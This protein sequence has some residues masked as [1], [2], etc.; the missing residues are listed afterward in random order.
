MLTFLAAKRMLGVEAPVGKGMI[1]KAPVSPAVRQ[2]VE[3]VRR[4]V[5]ARL[6]PDTTFEQRRAAGAALMA[7]AIAELLDNGGGEDQDERSIQ[8]PEVVHAP[9]AEKSGTRS[10]SK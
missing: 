8:P 1:E 2:L 10:E 7:E 6:G 4:E 9:R 5:E 3:R